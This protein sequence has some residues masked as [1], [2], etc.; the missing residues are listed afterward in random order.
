MIRRGWIGAHTALTQKRLCVL[1]GVP[2]TMVYVKRKP[3]VF[4]EVD[5]ALKRLIDEE[6]TRR[7]LRGMLGGRFA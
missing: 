7:F 4:V 2:R 6:Y 5:E 3:V 1:A